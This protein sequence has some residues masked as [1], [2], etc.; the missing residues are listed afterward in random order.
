MTTRENKG[1]SGALFVGIF[2]GFCFVVAGGTLLLTWSAQFEK[3]VVTPPPEIGH[4]L[5]PRRS[6]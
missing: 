2:L 3:P 1:F 4:E 6:D 5:V